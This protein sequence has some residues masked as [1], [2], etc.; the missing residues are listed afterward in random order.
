MAIKPAET[1]EETMVPKPC[2]IPE[3]LVPPT[4]TALY[5][6]GGV[7]CGKTG[8]LVERV[9]SLLESGAL[10]G[11]IL[12]FCATPDAAAEFSRRLADACRHG[13]L[14]P[15]TTPREWCRDVL[16][17]KPARIADTCGGRMLAPFEVDILMEDLK[18]CGMRPQ[19]LRE[20]LKFFY[21]SMTELCD[22][23]EEWLLTGEEIQ[24]YGL[25]RECL[26]FEGAVLEAELANTVARWLHDDGRAL[27]A[28]EARHVI[29]DDYQMLSRASQVLANELANDSIAVAA[30][31]ALSVE[32]FE[33]Y[34]YAAGIDEFL[35]ANPDARRV[36]LDE[37]HACAAAVGAVNGIADD[38][39]VGAGHVKR[40]NDAADVLVVERAETPV[41]ERDLV[42]SLV[43]KA[44]ATGARPK[45]VA[46]VVPNGVWGRNI[47]A[48]LAA[49]GIAASSPLAPKSV[50]GDLRELDRC[51]AARVLT[52]LYLV[53]DP[54]DGVA[55][56]SWCGF[57]NLF[58][59]STAAKDIR[60][61]AL[62]EG[63]GAAEAF[64]SAEVGVM[65]ET[66]HVE[67]TC[68]TD[69][70][71]SALSI[72]E[73]AKGKQG[74]DLLAY[75]TSEVA[76]AGAKVPAEVEALVAPLSDGKLAGDDAAAMAAR[77]RLRIDAPRLDGDDETV[78]V[79]SLAGVTG[80]TP[81][82]AVRCGFVNGF[83]PS[84]GVL[85]RD[86][87]AKEDADK[88]M[89]KDLRLLMNAV[90]KPASGLCVTY[91]DEVA[92]EIADRLGMKMRRVQ[93]HDGKRVALSRP[94]VY[95]DRLEV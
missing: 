65:G 67:W 27:T 43:Q 46:V 30:N 34:P 40:A 66:M 83:F 32:V 17:T 48:A 77:A 81:S 63:I 79:V 4:P 26:D 68:V 72:L 3:G 1:I 95:L 33:S 15:V 85:D 47:R 6:E 73:G 19:R 38:E 31:P 80:T 9:V 56:R 94:S 59:S 87:L 69:G 14:V 93:L 90:G 60:T 23:D 28:H 75:I 64:S 57:G 52:A 36:V 74:H 42:V 20:M 41:Q 5:V 11:D 53:A 16:A 51:V 39:L 58:V 50:S 29:V 61:A 82:H 92:L 86:I 7:A 13:A 89:A 22:W 21:K 84:K 24:T 10:P 71:R 49:A 37:S 54:K 12:V 62:A 45:D 8:V 91:F 44:L 2:P 35:A 70:Q 55:W 18:T 78:R 25:L 88:Q 76:G